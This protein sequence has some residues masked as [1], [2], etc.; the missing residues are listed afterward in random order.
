MTGK[1]MCPRAASLV[2]EVLHRE[3]RNPQ[4]CLDYSIRFDVLNGGI[5]EKC[6]HLSIDFDIED[7]V[8]YTTSVENWTGSVTKCLLETG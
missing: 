4:A 8:W 2:L 6:R 1:S 3:S 5:Q 7:R